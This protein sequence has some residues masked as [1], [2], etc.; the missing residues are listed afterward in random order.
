MDGCVATC[1]ETCAG[2][3]DV[4]IKDREGR[5]ERVRAGV[6][7]ENG[8]ACANDRDVVLLDDGM[9][10]NNSDDLRGVLSYWNM[11]GRDAHHLDATDRP[12]A[13]QS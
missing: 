4:S 13:A 9:D 12:L 2:T 10:S 1:V 5:G 11:L 6:D 3:G 8:D 7:V